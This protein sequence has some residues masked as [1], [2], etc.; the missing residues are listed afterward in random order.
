[1]IISLRLRIFLYS[2]F[3]L[4]LMGS[5]LL[6]VLQPWLEERNEETIYQRLKTASA[7][8]IKTAA[9]H[10]GDD[11]HDLVRELSQACACRVS[12][13][14]SQGRLLADSLL[15]PDDFAHQED[16]GQR[17][18][19]V[20]ALL[21]GLGSSLRHSSSLAER[22]LYLAQPLPEREI[23]L[24]FSSAPPARPLALLPWP[25]L[26]LLLGGGI[27]LLFLSARLLAGRYERPVREIAASLPDLAQG[28]ATFLWRALKYDPDIARLG[29]GLEAAAQAIKDKFHKLGQDAM[30]LQS[31]LQGMAEPVL[32]VNQ[33]K[34]ISLCNQAAERLLGTDILGRNTASVIRSAELPAALHRAA[35]EKEA[36]RE[37]IFLP[38]GQ[39]WEAVCSP[40]PETAGLA[41][42]VV[43]LHNITQAKQ[44]E[45]IRRDFVANFSHELRTPLAVIQ[46]AQET[47]SGF[48]TN[49]EGK[50]FL[51]SI[52]RQT[53]RLQA[54]LDDLLKL[55]RLESPEWL[56]APHQPVAVAR[57]IHEAGRALEEK[58]RAA[59]VTVVIEPLPDI[60]IQAEAHT[61]EQAL[62]NLLDNAVKY[63]PAG[64]RVF[65]RAGR[66]EG[67][68]EIA[69]ED[70]GPG[71]APEHQERIFERFYR[72]DKSR[73]SLPGSTGLGL[74]IARHAARLHGGE[75][76][77]KSRLNR[78][79][80][81]YLI[82][83]LAKDADRED[84]QLEN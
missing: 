53:A 57:L 51:D 3:C 28:Q 15:H 72:V 75:V 29:Q 50:R 9:R 6:L 81:F 34:R 69:V 2:L 84:G 39:V 35:R 31:L 61:L 4:A 10:E 64:G 78:G 42:V 18:E 21:T 33:D 41:E 25:D 77:L 68:L 7:L 66:S 82:V 38:G 52:A 74:A 20:E 12:V 76:K 67:R 22:Q 24:R 8:S 43:I 58:A 1:M 23:V 55:A 36:V 13:I 79:S 54:I 5:G 11:W 40:L 62:V 48:F 14:T 19:I 44:L 83:P 30:R 56:T 65:V 37:E 63:S 47:L 71:I 26:L 73:A 80:V 60:I 59:Q 17:K 46:A 16:H 49:D 45:N 27:L 32:A 70:S